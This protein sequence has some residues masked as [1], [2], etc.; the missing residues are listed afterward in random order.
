MDI[1]KQEP[2]KER[3]MHSRFRK[4]AKSLHRQKQFHLDQHQND[5]ASSSFNPC[6]KPK[7]P[8]S[9]PKPSS[10]SLAEEQKGALD[11]LSVGMDQDQ[12][13]QW[14]INCLNVSLDPSKPEFTYFFLHH[15]LFLC[16][17]ITYSPVEFLFSLAIVRLTHIH[18][19]AVL[20]EQFIR[21]HWNEDEEGFEHPVVE[22]N[23]K[24]AVKGLLLAL[25][26]DP[27]KEIR[28][29][30]SAAVSAIAL[31]DWPEDWPELVP[32]LLTLIFL[33]SNL[34]VVHGA[35]LCLSL[36]S[37]DM[38]DKMV[39]RLVADLFPY[40]HFL[41]PQIYDT[42]LRSKALSLIYNC[43]S[44]SWA[45][46]GA[47]EEMETTTEMLKP[48]MEIFSS[49][50]F[51]PVPSEDPD[52]WSIRKEVIKCLNQ[53]IQNF[54]TVTKTY[55]AVIQWPF[56]E[57]FG[58][59]LEVYERSAIEG[60]E[61]SYN[62]GYDSDGAEQS[63]ESF[64]I[65]L[66]KFL[67]TATGSPRFVKV[68]MNDVY[69]LVYY[70]IGFLQMTERQVHSW[71]NDANK[72]VADEDNSSYC[73]V[74]VALLLQDVVSKC[75]AEGI[76]AVIECVEMRR[77][78]S[79]QAK[80]TGSP[81]WW[82]LREAALYALA[83]LASVP[84]QLLLDEVEVSGSTVGAM[85]WEIL[86]DDMAEGFHDYPF[87]CARLFSTVARFS[88]MMNNQVTDDFICAAIKTVGMDVPPLVKFGACR[89]LSKLL[90]DATTGIVQNSTVD[91]F[92]SLIDL[93]KNASDESMH[94]VLETL[95]AALAA[96][97]GAIKLQV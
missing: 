76:K 62:D 57:T 72:Y 13:P 77:N 9:K 47:Y 55:F 69:E 1:L 95:Q 14:M 28:I 92:S 21:E 84:E 19:A 39:P 67:L 70:T 16:V 58:S 15:L 79:Q 23:E 75:G 91:L 96:G 52:D 54:P 6:S 59:T 31:Y 61:N 43:T 83:A 36:L 8:K 42:S 82:R 11:Y 89:A 26:D 81:G 90:P 73:R 22:S 51:E 18:L 66:F 87:L 74:H 12:D 80:D 88:S 56:W 65:E 86:S 32:S 53:F 49:I 68:V 50:L 5:P 64:V 93:Q 41:F 17:T 38:D 3:Q 4:V 60:N 45:M 34:N 37:S 35:L 71:S 46:S 25:L 85:L 30:V 44:I 48:W 97:V 10:K 33:Q 2:L 94:L 7:I 24:A 78:E 27:H 20:L 29:A 63:L 40:L